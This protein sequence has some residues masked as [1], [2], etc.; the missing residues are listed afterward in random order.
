MSDY[1]DFIFKKTEY[2]LECHAEIY[3][4]V[5]LI[6]R[7]DDVVDDVIRELDSHIALCA[8]EMVSLNVA[9]SADYLKAFILTKRRKATIENMK[10]WAEENRT[11]SNIYPW[12][13]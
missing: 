2:F 4:N 1:R 6:I 3:E 10:K 5:E 7:S 12:S 9:L 13:K 11:A 8:H